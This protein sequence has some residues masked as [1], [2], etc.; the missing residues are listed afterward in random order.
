[1]K[2][3]NLLAL[4]LTTVSVIV[5]AGGNACAQIELLKNGS[6]ESDEVA[7]GGYQYG[8]PLDWT[9]V[10]PERFYIDNGNRPVVPAPIPDGLN[11]LGSSVVIDTNYQDLTLNQSFTLDLTS[12][13]E[14]S[15]WSAEE[16]GLSNANSS[17]ALYDSSNNLVASLEAA[18][19][20][21][22]WARHSLTTD[23]LAPGTYI[24]SISIA[25]YGL[26]DAYSVIAVPETSSVILMGTSLVA[27][28]FLRR[29]RA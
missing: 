12:S 25:Q 4:L 29:R 24:F 22:G 8:A 11:V 26:T 16:A 3:L 28:V 18:A 21:S 17:I 9:S 6:F 20:A 13:L 14:I 27:V 10:S 23:L 15:W 2:K 19:P 7:D 1:M 5:G